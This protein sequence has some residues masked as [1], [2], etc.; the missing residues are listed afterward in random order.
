MGRTFVKK[1]KQDSKCLLTNAGL[2]GDAGGSRTAV[3]GRNGSAPLGRRPRPLGESSHSAI[4]RERANTHRRSIKL[5]GTVSFICQRE[6]NSSTHTAR[7]TQKFP[8][9]AR[10]IY[11]FTQHKQREGLW[12]LCESG[13]SCG[14][15]RKLKFAFTKEWL[16]DCRFNRLTITHHPLIATPLSHHAYINIWMHGCKMK[17]PARSRR[18][19]FES[20]PCGHIKGEFKVGRN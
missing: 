13:A 5:H 9:A 7:C 8:R 18:A 10:L 11:I 17:A 6:K 3:L 20:I 12:W 2:E 15:H 4:T 16:G 19:Q 14:R 1:K